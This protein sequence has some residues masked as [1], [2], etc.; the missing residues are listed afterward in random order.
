MTRIK[1]V[2]QYIYEKAR[3]LFWA[4]NKFSFFT[5]YYNQLVNNQTGMAPID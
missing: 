1:L 4:D 2:C 3:E 5:A